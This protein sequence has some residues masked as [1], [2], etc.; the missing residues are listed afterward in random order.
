MSAI[1]RNCPSRLAYA[2]KSRHL[3]GRSSPV[4]CGADTLPLFLLGHFESWAVQVFHS[5][6]MFANPPEMPLK[7]TGY[8]IPIPG[9]QVAGFPTK[10]EMIVRNLDGG[11]EEVRCAW[12]SPLT[13]LGRDSGPLQRNWGDFRSI[14]AD[15]R[16][17]V[18]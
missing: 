4:Y 5:P 8:S 11:T 7:R 9:P 13:S 6:A 16:G 12:L 1:R 14:Q 10:A 2:V 18:R 17:Q 15:G 3:V